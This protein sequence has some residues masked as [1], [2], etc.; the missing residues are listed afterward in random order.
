MRSNQP[1]TN[2]NHIIPQNKHNR[3]HTGSDDNNLVAGGSTRQ[4]IMVWG[5]MDA[6]IMRR[7]VLV[8]GQ[9]CLWRED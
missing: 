2:A 8:I 9:P 5:Q 7:A 6:L 3:V 4:L 1:I